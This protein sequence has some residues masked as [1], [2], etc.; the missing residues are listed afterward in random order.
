MTKSLS[1]GI[2]Y[3]TSVILNWL[4]DKLYL[5]THVLYLFSNQLQWRHNER[6]DVSNHQPHH[7]LL[8]R[9]FRRRGKKTS[10]LRV[11]GLCARNS[12]VTGEFPAQ[13]T[14]NAE[15]VSIW[16]GHH[17]HSLHGELNQIPQVSNDFLK[18]SDNRIRKIPSW[19]AMHTPKTDYGHEYK[20]SNIENIYKCQ[21]NYAPVNH[22][23]QMYNLQFHHLFCSY[24]IDINNHAIHF[25]FMKMVNMLF[26]RKNNVL[27]ILSISWIRER[28][29]SLGVILNE[30]GWK[31]CNLNKIQCI[32]FR[33]MRL[34]NS[35]AKCWPF[36]SEW[37][38]CISLLHVW[39]PTIYFWE[40]I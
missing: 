35:S 6:D 12:P 16:W 39:F 34:N 19:R 28:Q 5:A 36:Y 11:T 7:C 1:N 23:M 17:A 10:K 15:N 33:K 3:P 27:L 38:E 31:F 20:T 40:H 30:R 26:I 2:K 32:A 24:S 25:I 9:L 22:I 37:L 21:R 13:R 8:N 14:S 4:R 29:L 18:L